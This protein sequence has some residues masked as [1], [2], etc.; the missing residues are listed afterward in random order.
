MT[1]EAAVEFWLLKSGLTDCLLLIAEVEVVAVEDKEDKVAAL[2]R[3][4]AQLEQAL[5]LGLGSQ[6]LQKIFCNRNHG[7]LWYTWDSERDAACNVEQE[8]ITGYLSSLEIA[9]GQYKGKP[10]YTAQLGL[11]C[12][13]RE[14]VLCAGHQSAFAK[15][16]YF[17][18]A[19]LEPGV[20]RENP[21]TIC[22]RAGNEEK[23]LMASVFVAGE[24][25]KGEGWSMT[26]TSDEIRAALKAARKNILDAQ[27]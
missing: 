15:C 22:P 20:L 6:P 16:L 21:V 26:T 2:E 19:A 9:K 12:G 13:P 4:V 7:G 27:C 24:L 18:I 5:S 17:A 1:A 14:F 11:R 10:T 8:A 25:V 23:T 3:R